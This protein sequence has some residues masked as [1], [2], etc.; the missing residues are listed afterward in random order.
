MLDAL[1]ARLQEVESDAEIRAVVSRQ[2]C[3]ESVRRRGGHPRDVDDGTG[4]AWVHEAR[5]QAVTVAIERSPMPV[6]AAV[7]GSCLGGRCEIAL[8]CDLVLASDDARFGQPALN[9]GVCPDGEGLSVYR[10][11][12]GPPERGS[13]Y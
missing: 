3:R 12:S 11:G 7:N 13:G 5:G 4:E 8:A 1:L 6:I 2:R 10:D 9:L